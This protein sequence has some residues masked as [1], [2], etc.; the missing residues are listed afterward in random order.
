[1]R[2][3][4]SRVA[5]CNI[6]LATDLSTGPFYPEMICRRC[7]SRIARQAQGLPASRSLSTTTSRLVEAVTAQTTTASNPR[8]NGVPAATSTSAAQPFSTPL[9]PAPDPHVDFS[10]QQERSKAPV[11]IASSVPAGTVLKG[12]NFMK[13]KQDPVAMEDHEY[14]AWLW[15][16]LA[17]K[18]EQGGKDELEGDLFGKTRSHA[19][20]HVHSSNAH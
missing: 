2:H 15:D 14:P 12:L 8:P 10:S 17:E 7:L 13:N 5:G 1:M 18:K 3:T 11:K 6:P 16:V 20:N 4:T 19:T 9:S